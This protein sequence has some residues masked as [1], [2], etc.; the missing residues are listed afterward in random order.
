MHSLNIV[1]GLIAG[2]LC[3]LG[4]ALKGSLGHTQC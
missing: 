1:A 3:A 4:G 2:T